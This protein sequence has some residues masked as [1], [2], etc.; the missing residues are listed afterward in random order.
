MAALENIC[1]ILVSFF[2]FE[3]NLCLYKMCEIKIRM[4]YKDWKKKKKRH[5]QKMRG[6]KKFEIINVLNSQYLHNF[7]RSS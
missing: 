5:R 1:N 2:T 7:H 4:G 3:M 6:K